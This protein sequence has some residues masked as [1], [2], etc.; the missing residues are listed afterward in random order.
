MERNHFRL[1]SYSILLITVFVFL[2]CESAKDSDEG[3]TEV[4]ECGNGILE[5]GEACDDGNQ[6]VTDACLPSCQL[7]S[8]GD[9]YIQDSV[10]ECDDAN[11][12]NIDGCSNACRFPVCGNGIVELNEECD[13]GEANSSSVADACRPNCLKASC[14][15]GVLDSNEEC[16]DANLIG[17]DG[18]TADC[19]I[20]EGWSC[21]S[22]LGS[23]S[24]CSEDCIL[25]ETGDC[26]CS[27][28]DND[29]VCDGVDNCPHTSNIGQ[30]DSDDD[31]V[32][33]ACELDID[34][35]GFSGLEDFAPE[36]PNS[37]P[38]AEEICDGVD[39]N[40]NGIIDEG[41]RCEQ[42]TE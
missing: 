9:G 13:D 24:I 14:G 17:E 35:D 20:E 5:A 38:G 3:T 23:L 2:G 30:L 15:D 21:D 18:C 31:G 11:N 37:F 25:D 8:C 39:N 16:D 34:G 41:T 29:S 42:C 32:G 22:S 28:S 33:D 6:I 10:E 12:S 19:S 4:A 40:S 36:D 27:D 26:V 1:I 7:A